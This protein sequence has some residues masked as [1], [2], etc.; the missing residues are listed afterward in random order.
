MTHILVVGQTLSGKSVLAKRL[1]NWHLSKGIGVI[2]QDP[3]GDPGW[4]ESGSDLF[5]SFTDPDEFLDFVQDPDSCL[6]CLII[7]DEAG[8]S[9][10]KR[11]DR[12]NWLTCQSRH[13]GHRA[14]I[15]G[16]RAEMIPKSIRTQCSTLYAFNINP[17]DAKNYAADFN[18]PAINEAPNLPQGHYIKVERFQPVKRGRLW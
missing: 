7:V 15:I 13:H 14:M 18:N 11:A 4:N 5:K 10:D 9:L 1:A 8:L 3:M 2:V 16:N 17:S 12:F 6:Q